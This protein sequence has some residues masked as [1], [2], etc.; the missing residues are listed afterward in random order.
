MTREETLSPIF[1]PGF[2]T[3]KKSPEVDLFLFDCCRPVKV[4]T[5][6]RAN[7]HFLRVEG[8]EANLY[9]ALMRAMMLTF[10]CKLF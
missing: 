7:E 1:L 2:S 5:H 6:L 3:S 9:A 10:V 8:G 4:P